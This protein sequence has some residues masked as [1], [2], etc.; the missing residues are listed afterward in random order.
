MGT[1][2]NKEEPAQ[3]SPVAE[4]EQ[5]IED[6][7]VEEDKIAGS[8]AVPPQEPASV[9]AEEPPAMVADKSIGNSM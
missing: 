2:Q 1:K 9:S 8:I 7:L 6:D 4:P 3:E 5:K